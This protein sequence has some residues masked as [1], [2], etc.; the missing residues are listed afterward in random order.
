MRANLGML[1]VILAAFMLVTADSYGQVIS[2]E[3]A[4]VESPAAG[5]QLTLNINIA[6]GMNIAGYEVT[7]TF[8]STALGQVSIVNGDYL[9]E[10]A[11]IVPAVVTETSI[12]LAA[13]ALGATAEGDGTLATVSFTVIE[14]KASTIA[15]DAIISDPTAT[16]IGATVEG[17]VVTA[18][19]IDAPGVTLA[20][21]DYT[22]ET[23]DVEGVD[24]LELTASSEFD[25]YAGNTR[26]PD[27]EK[28]VGFTL[29]DGVFMTYDFPGSKNTYFYALG[30][31]GQ[32]AGHYEDSDGLYHGVVLEDGELR[33]YDFPD[34]VQTEI[35]GISDATGALT[36]NYID[37]SGVRRGFSGD[38]IVEAPGASATYADFVNASGAMVG[39]YIDAD[40]LYEAYVRT[41]DGRFVYLFGLSESERAELEYFFVHGINDAR[42]IVAR[43]QAVGDVP[44]TYVG[45]YESDMFELRFPG[46]V[47]TEG[48]N[49]NQDGS[50]VGH[51][52]SADGRRHG[53]VA[54]PT[55]EL[56]ARLY[57]VPVVGSTR[58]DYT[59]ESIDVEGVDFLALTASSDFGGYAG[60]TRSPDGEK[61]VG[62]TLIDGVFMTYDFPGSKNTYFY[63]LS[64]TGIAAGH[65]EDSDGLYHGVVLEGGG[66]RQYDFP[67]A[68][69]TEIYGISDATGVLTGNYID[70]SGVRRGFSGDII[71]AFPGASAT[72]AN[73]AAEGGFALGSDLI[74]G[75]YI[76]AEGAYHLYV[77]NPD[78]SFVGPP[79][80]QITRYQSF[81]VHGINDAG[82]A[83]IQRQVVGD[84]PRTYAGSFLVGLFTLETSSPLKFETFFTSHELQFPGS[85]STAGWNV[86]QDGSV[87]GHYDSADGRRHGFIARPTTGTPPPVEKDDDASGVI[88]SWAVHTFEGDPVDEVFDDVF[89][90]AEIV[91]VSKWTFYDD[92]R[93]N[94]VTA[95]ETGTG[96]PL[97]GSFSFA[98]GG[99]YTI[100]GS[101]YTL[102]F[103]EETIA[104]HEIEPSEAITTG[105]WMRA[106]STLTLSHDDGTVIVMHAVDSS[107]IDL[108]PPVGSTHRFE[109]ELASGLNMISLPL[110]PAA[111]YTARSFAEAV[112]ATV[113]IELDTAMSQFVGFTADQSGDGFAIEGGQGYI[114]NVPGGGVVSF[115]GTAW[116]N[117]MEKDAAAAPGIQL[118][119]TT[120][121]FVVSGDLR[122][123]EA[124]A[125][126]TVVAKNQRTGEV[127]TRQV[128]SDD[129]TFNAVWA[130][131][132]RGSVIEVGDTLEVVLFDDLGNIVSG[133]FTHQVGVDHLQNAYLSLPLTVGDVHPAK[134]LLGQNF[135]NPFNP[136]TWIPYQLETSADVVL[137]IYDPSGGV[138][139]TID[140]GFKPQGFYLTRSKAAYWDGRN[141]MGET[142]ASGVYFYSLQT[143]D[144]S[145]TQKMLILK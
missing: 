118:P 142:V 60:Y 117:T 62:F 114:V 48:W 17:G 4:S 93:W 75:S 44:R 78:G 72:Y 26:S 32:A 144:F 40:G 8:D 143:P 137:Q 34:A 128:T 59:F 71:V 15:L 131:L 47:S 113:V 130:D 11:F 16:P 79:L 84:V 20:N 109:L 82:V 55:E 74:V 124:G 5:E 52:D 126:Y 96:D 91:G 7:L 22:F 19:V 28:T 77:R 64:N 141:N 139:R 33:Q 90:G 63:A 145:A 46:S 103:D 43:S 125:S 134:T 99:T 35:Y 68:V 57:D 50:I 95:F 105:T 29:I 110:M 54:R 116:D 108:P 13:T 80:P 53:F 25:D 39:S 129:K 18:P 81:F 94:W 87:V 140:I 58:S 12:K 37:G 111:P 101:S 61:A 92:G 132:T 38:I 69:Q 24:F 67:D 88:G 115:T 100:T 66:L 41:P 2:I 83:V 21:A 135:P 9:P 138:V 98:I 31:D 122:E 119:S 106:D 97:S 112:G 45:L 86:N 120:W 56:A 127:A 51:Y 14:A 36:G 121:A 42:V 49:I 70:G 107:G 65:Y 6:G 136:E 1:L 3:P 85:V 104:R 10:G 27:G 76:D 73:F 123:T 30:N 133:P 102:I 89:E 23:I